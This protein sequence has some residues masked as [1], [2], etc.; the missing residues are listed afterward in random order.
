MIAAEMHV[1]PGRPVPVPDDVTRPYWEAA[2]A[3][4]LEIQRC[5]RCKLYYHPPVAICTSCHGEE[6]KFEPVSGRGTVYSY[7]ITHEARTPAFTALQP[8][9]VVWIELE[10]Q[11]RLRLVSSMPSTPLA[12]IR[13]DVQV[14]VYFDTITGDTAIPVFRLA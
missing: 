3:G 9:A 7:T 4:R 5:Q 6:L 13:C 10:E 11:A 1:V 14:E 12:G 2:S 8:Y